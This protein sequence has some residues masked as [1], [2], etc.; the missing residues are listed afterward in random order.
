MPFVSRLPARRVELPFDEGHWVEVRAISAGDLI[1]L[2][3]RGLSNG[4]ITLELLAK[5][6]TSWS[7]DV[8]VTKDAIGD[9]DNDTFGFLEKQ[10]DLST[11]IRS[12]DEKNTEAP[13]AA[14]VGG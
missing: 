12:N 10:L 6:I 14:V 2:Q 9:L 13:A 3:G 1:D 8:P 7:F 11:G 4:A 5:C